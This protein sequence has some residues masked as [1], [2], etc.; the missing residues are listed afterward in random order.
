MSSFSH[1]TVLLKETVAF[2]RPRST[3][4]YIDCT[5]GGAGHTLELLQQ[6]APDGQLLC[7]DQ[8][9]TALNNARVVLAD[10]LQTRV[11][12]V[13]ANFR[14]VGQ[15]ARDQG[16]YSVDGV[17][18]DLGVSSPQFDEADRGFS[19]R[20]DAVLDMRMDT[21]NDK[22][23]LQLVNEWTEH[24]LSRVFSEYGEE[25]F[26]RKIARAI[27]KK[28]ADE[29][30]RTTSELAEIVKGAIPAAAR[31]SGGHPAKKVFQ[32]LRIEVNDELNALREA[33]EQAFEL[34]TPGGRIAAIS[35]HSLEDRIVKQTF[36]KFAEGC[37]CP[38]DF[39][40]CQC[41][42]TPKADIV[43]RKPIMPSDEEQ[44]SNP[45]S[46]SAKLRVVQKR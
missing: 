26:H 22:T 44:Q 19:Y 13:H 11:N 20:Y 3:G 2:L 42:R 9:L 43:T 15:V 25:K 40:I 16:F 8:D 36:L 38:S 21:S 4:R 1:Q 10:F 29:E 23:A 34:L 24:Q 30:I 18:F 41:G 46:K 6:S 33:L 35:F 12:L 45:R 7:F 14:E 39:P 37:I 5:L 17:V 28:R 31:R 27:V 32:A